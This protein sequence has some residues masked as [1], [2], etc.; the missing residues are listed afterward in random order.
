MVRRER[1]TSRDELVS[2][3]NLIA[4]RKSS[5]GR[6]ENVKL[7]HN[8][9]Q[10]IFR[11][12]YLL[13]KERFEVITSLGWWSKLLLVAVSYCCDIFAGGSQV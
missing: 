4:L 12:V 6:D 2:V 9:M 10:S 8:E 5:G 13:K 11:G 3:E 1:M 7:V